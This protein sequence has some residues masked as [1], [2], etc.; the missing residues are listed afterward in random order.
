MMHAG[1][2]YRCTDPRCGSEIQV[3][4]GSQQRGG[5]DAP[6]CCCGRDMELVSQSASAMEGEARVS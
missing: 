3:L 1:E 4:K 5:D 6:R 2:T